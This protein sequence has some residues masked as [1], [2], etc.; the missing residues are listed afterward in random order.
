M[1]RHS[2]EREKI[3]IYEILN[4]KPPSY[5]HQTPLDAIIIIIIEKT[6][7]VIMI[8]DGRGVCWLVECL[9]DDEGGR[10]QGKSR[11][12]TGILTLPGPPPPPNLNLKGF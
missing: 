4:L 11:E 7:I 8:N 12:A 6:F 9:W 2:L 3:H 5:Y 1:N 10:N